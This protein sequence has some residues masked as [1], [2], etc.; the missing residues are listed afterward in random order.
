MIILSD[1]RKHENYLMQDCKGARMQDSVLGKYL[2]L[3]LK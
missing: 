2:A 3:I 1:T